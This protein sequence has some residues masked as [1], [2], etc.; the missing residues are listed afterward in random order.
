MV[1]RDKRRVDRVLESPFLI[2]S[3]CRNMT[4]GQAW[5]ERKARKLFAGWLAGLASVGAEDKKKDMILRGATGGGRN[6]STPSIFH[7]DMRIDGGGGGL[8]PSSLVDLRLI[9]SFA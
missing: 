6:G 4:L 5:R 7:K 8:S 2:L 9:C 1:L 3:S